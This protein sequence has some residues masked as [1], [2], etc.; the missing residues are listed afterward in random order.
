MTREEHERDRAE[1]R[2]AEEFAAAYLTFGTVRVGGRA[3]VELLNRLFASRKSPGSAQSN[4][5]SPAPRTPCAGGP[6]FAVT[7]EREQEVR[8]FLESLGVDPRPWTVAWLAEMTDD[9]WKAA[10]AKL[11]E[12]VHDVRRVLGEGATPQAVGLYVGMSDDEW[13]VVREAILADKDFTARFEAVRFTREGEVRETLGRVGLDPTPERIDC[14]LRMADETWQAVR[15]ALIS[16]ASPLLADA[17]RRAAAH[18][19]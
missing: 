13:Q 11:T 4:G 17:E 3:V 6:E 10:Q 15:D 7:P 19:G 18:G 2:K 5:R 8:G 14:Y 1:R 16:T 9:D 12:R